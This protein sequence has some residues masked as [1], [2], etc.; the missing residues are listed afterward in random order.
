MSV[1]F[2][3]TLLSIP[4]RDFRCSELVSFANRLS[5]ALARISALPPAILDGEPE[6]SIENRPESTCGVFLIVEKAESGACWL[7]AVLAS[8]TGD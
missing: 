4:T 1:D 2:E 6:W 5:R 3:A 8:A 7:D